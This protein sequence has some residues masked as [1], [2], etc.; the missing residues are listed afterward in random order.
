VFELGYRGRATPSLTYSAT[1]FLQKWDRLRSGTTRPLILENKIEGPVYGLEAWAAWQTTQ[2]WRLSGG[3]TTFRKHL[4]LKPGSTDPLG[5][6]NPILGNDLTYQWMLRSSISFGG[7]HESE[8]MMRR[9]GEL[10][11]P[12]VPAYAAVDMRYAW[13]PRKELELSVTGQNLFDRSHPEFGGEY[14]R[15]EFTRA[16]LLQVR[17]SH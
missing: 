14:G 17:W 12:S 6:S 13:R 11:D 1:A 15:S 16:V 8:V 9:V 7:K 2:I 4:R 3:L 10:P 5:T